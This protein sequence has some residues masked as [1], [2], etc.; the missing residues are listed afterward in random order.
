M[1]EVKRCEECCLVLL[2]GKNRFCDTSCSAKWRNKQ[3]AAIAA[4]LSQQR[5]DAVS[6]GLKRAHANNPEW[7]A[8]SSRRMRSHNPTSRPEVMAKI[9]EGW[10]RTG[11]PITKQQP[12]GGNGRPLPRAQRILWAALGPSWKVEH[13]IPTGLS[14]PAGTPNSY[15]VDLALPEEKIWIEVDGWSHTLPKHRKQDRKKERTLKAL[16]WSGLRFSNRQVEE[17]LKGT[18][19]SISKFQATQPTSQTGC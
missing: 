13:P 18:L 6:A 16:G 14:R 7:A 2:P 17:D 8:E 12:R 9:K 11:H 1:S 15:K 10:E 3:P 4:N 19:S 5:R